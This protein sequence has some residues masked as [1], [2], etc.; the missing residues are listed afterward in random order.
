MAWNKYPYLDNHELNLDWFLEQFKLLLAAWDDLQAAW[1]AYKEDL[2]GQWEEVETAWQTYKNYIDNY[3]ANLNVQT[4]INNKINSMVTSGE[5]LNVISPT[6]ILQTTS[7]TSRWLAEHIAQETGYVLD[8]SLTVSGAAADA[9]AVG[10]KVNE[11]SE[12]ILIEHKELINI[13]TIVTD[14]LVIP[15]GFKRGKRFLDTGF[16]D[17]NN[18]ALSKLYQPGTYHIS[19]TP[20]A[21]R[22]VKYVSPTQGI[23]L[24]EWNAGTITFTSDTP[25]YI[26]FT[27]VTTDDILNTLNNTIVLT[28]ILSTDGSDLVSKLDDLTDTVDNNLKSIEFLE[29]GSA[30]IVMDKNPGYISA[31]GDFNPPVNGEIYSQLINV[32]TGDIITLTVDIGADGTSQWIAVADYSINE[33][34]IKRNVLISGSTDRV[35]TLTYV[36]KAGTEFIRISCRQYTAGSIVATKKLVT[37][38]QIDNLAN[39]I[40]YI[41]FSVDKTVKSIAHRGDNFYGPQNTAPA[42]IIARQHGFTIAENDLNL[43]EDGYYVMEHDINLGRLGNMVDINGYLMYTDG[44]NYYWVDSNNDVYTWTGSEYQISTVQINDLTRCAGSDYGVNSTYGAIGLNFDILRRIDFGVWKGEKFKGTQILTFTEWVMLC[45]QLGMEIYIDRK[46]NYTSEQITELANIVKKYGMA[47]KASWLG[48]DGAKIIALRNVIPGARC[49][50]LRHPTE[51]LVEGYAQYN[52]GQGFFF[53]GDAR[54]ATEEAIQLGLNAGFE[55]EVWNVEYSNL[56]EEQ[57]FE[58]IRTAVSYGITGMTLDHYLVKEAYS[59]LFENY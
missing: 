30:Y 59:Y 4:E 1:T 9:K 15:N 36:V 49:C 58:S 52:V 32:V 11:L 55:V 46:I 13:S 33:T 21:C 44:T 41:S 16:S 35:V 56:S 28:Q 34:F 48:M 6:V 37:Q 47:E 29:N 18:Y 57:I 8:T 42:Y 19:N 45:K 20:N 2:T 5:F 12:D 14:T 25:F 31:N 10:D 51:A 26:N 54:A 38:K 23:Y 43:S 50:L 7:E 27:G 22:V 39:Q 24:T 17:A 3:F 40:D 53:N